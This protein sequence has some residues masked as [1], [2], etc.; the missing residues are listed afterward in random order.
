[1]NF[2]TERLMSIDS[3]LIGLTRQGNN[4]QK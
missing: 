2:G 4:V 3:S 1:M